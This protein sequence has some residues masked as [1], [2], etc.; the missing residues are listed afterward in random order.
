MAADKRRRPRRSRDAWRP[1]ATAPQ[2]GAAIVAA[3]GLLSQTLPAVADDMRGWRLLFGIGLGTLGA[4]LAVESVQRARTGAA[5][6]R[7]LPIIAA[8]VFAATVAFPFAATS[9]A[10]K[11]AS[12]AAKPAAPVVR[13]T[14][15][16][17]PA[18][19]LAFASDIGL[20]KRGDGWEQLHARGGIDVGQADSR[21]TL[22]N[23]SKL[24]ITVT[25]IRL[26]VVEVTSVPRGSV[27]LVSLQGEGEL[28]HFY[29]H[30]ASP[31]AGST[32][33]L[34]LAETAAGNPA[35]VPWFDRHYIRLAPGEI[36]EA[37][38]SVRS[39][40][41]GV[42]H[43]RFVASGST[44]TGRFVVR[45]APTLAVASVGD[46]RSES[47]SPTVRA[48]LSVLRES[49]LAGRDSAPAALPRALAHCSGSG[50]VADFDASRV[51]LDAGGEVARRRGARPAR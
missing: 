25:D 51:D 39:G 38:V 6:R 24:R 17:N 50:Y 43:Y 26:Q 31:T 28:R 16:A 19:I 37:K 7:L 20:P 21:V 23:P 9:P 35:T 36:Y 14:A 34:V 33:P 12:H 42:V 45:T 4:V 27:A 32:V 47:S 48:G 8:V 5:G 13:A 44:A 3:I 46:S 29:A 30:V 22:S 41:F 2:I 18:F 1:R 10:G 11:R 49:A 40:V 15:I